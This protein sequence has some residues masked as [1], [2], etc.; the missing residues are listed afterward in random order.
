MIHLSA[1]IMTQK[2]TAGAAI[3]DPAASGYP[4]PGDLV[5][6]QR[7]RAMMRPGLLFVLAMGGCTYDDAGASPDVFVSEVTSIPA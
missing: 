1:G 7:S 2:R 5:F 3:A 6:R 4:D